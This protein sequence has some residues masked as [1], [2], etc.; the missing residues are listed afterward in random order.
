M[1]VK[2]KCNASLE[3][4]GVNGKYVIKDIEGSWNVTEELTS[5]EKRYF[6]EYL[7]SI[8]REVIHNE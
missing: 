4:Y 1:S 7:R 8:E 2:I 3:N 6:N 5:I